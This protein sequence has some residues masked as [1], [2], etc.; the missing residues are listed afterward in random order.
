[1]R[2]LN[3][4]CRQFLLFTCLFL[5]TVQTFVP[6]PTIRIQST[7][8]FN[9]GSSDEPSKKPKKRAKQPPKEPQK[10]NKQDLVKAVGEKMS[11][12]KKET[13]K[14]DNL[15]DKL[16]PFK[17]GQNLRKNIDEALTSIS[18]PESKKSIYLD[19]RLMDRPGY[20]SSSD[21]TMQRLGLDDD[22]VPEVLVVGATGEVGRRVVNRLLLE[23]RFRVR[24]LVRD[25]YTRTLEK[26]GTGVTYCQGDLDNMD[27]L[28]YALTDVD[29]I[30]FCA[31]APRPDEEDF[32]KKFQEYIQE[33]LQNKARQ[34]ESAEY[35]T[36]ITEEAK[37]KIDEEWEQLESILA[38][39][40]RLA[41][42]VDCT[43][44]QNLVRAYQH[45]R[46]ADYGTSQAAKRTLFKFQDRKGDFNLFSIDYDEEDGISRTGVASNSASVDDY[47]QYYEESEDDAIYSENDDMDDY[48]DLHSSMDI[49]NRKGASVKTQCQWI[50]NKFGNAVFVG[51][52]PK[53]IGNGIS[54]EAAVVSS[55]LRSREDPDNGIDLSNGFAGF[56][57]RLCSDGSNYEAFVRTKAYYDDGIEYVCEFSTSTKPTGR[58][59][60]SNKFTS[61]RLPFENFKPVRRL[62]RAKEIANDSIPAFRG[63]DVRNIGFRYRSLRNE[64]HS[65]SIQGE[66]LS[67]YLA[68]SYIKLYR[69]QPE[70]EFVYLSDARIPPIVRN[71]MVRHRARR[72]VTEAVEGADEGVKLL[73]ETILRS[74]AYIRTDRSQEETYYKYIG[75]DILRKSGLSYAIV[76]VCGYNESPSGEYSTLELRSDN[77]SVTAVSRTEVAE[78]CVSALLDPNALNK[79][80]Y[81]TKMRGKHAT[82]VDESLSKKF[83][84][85]LADT[86]V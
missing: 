31:S 60:S 64:L 75:E 48:R 32:R 22:Y 23:G 4:A 44:M 26:F 56:I 6:C 82:S 67:F 17:A 84:A 45:V 14:E 61:L 8:R 77:E 50:C 59:K 49:E 9:K 5:S 79:S 76:R 15:F 86:V 78:V 2:K 36:G 42:Q 24:V 30:V 13:V 68:L 18:L 66:L 62:D 43:G 7:A 51:R 28:E 20:S 74:A 38:V 41:E 12:A 57:C 65:K 69:S 27:S 37:D 10:M 70:P 34:L 80:F 46:H 39:R 73:D 21:P 35:S 72:L 85:L 29:K 54:G 55:R 58:N 25:L 52:V 1:M 81:V 3:V 16:N 19:D 63:E 71:H 33:T 53:R 83:A 40:A 11:K 47:L